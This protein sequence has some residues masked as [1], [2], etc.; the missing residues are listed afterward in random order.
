MSEFTQSTTLAPPQPVTDQHGFFWSAVDHGPLAPSEQNAW[1]PISSYAQD[2]V[3][4]SRQGDIVKH[5]RFTPE[6][7]DRLGRQLIAAA[8]VVRERQDGQEYLKQEDHS[9]LGMTL[10]M[11]DPSDG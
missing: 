2:T 10:G 7:A 9:A 3:R 1:S 6:E 4:L 11:L 5:F 8:A